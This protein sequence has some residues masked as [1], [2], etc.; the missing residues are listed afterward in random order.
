MHLDPQFLSANLW[1]LAFRVDTAQNNGKNG[2]LSEQNAELESTS[3]RGFA[4]CPVRSKSNSNPPGNEEAESSS[5]PSI[6]PHNPAKRRRDRVPPPQRERIFQKYVA[7]KSVAQISREESRNR[8]TVTRIVR[9]DQMRA[10]VKR[11]REEYLGLG[12]AALIAL[13]H[14]LEKGKDGK[15][16]YRVLVDSGV[17]PRA[18][19]LMQILA[20]E[21][22]TQGSQFGRIA[23]QLLLTAIERGRTF[24]YDVPEAEDLLKKAGYRVDA[25]LKL[26]PLNESEKL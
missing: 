10:H 13:R 7:G 1:G 4:M 19:E 5:A 6:N 21:E 24:G 25:Q 9:S 17:V 18:S 11:L 20:T 15:L 2:A 26:V 14:A 8:E 23:A 22:S 12:D 3:S 16:A